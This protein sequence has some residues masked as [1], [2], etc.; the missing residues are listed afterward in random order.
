[1]RRALLDDDIL[2]HLREEERE[3]SR[4]LEAIRSVIAV[5]APA[6]I[7]NPPPRARPKPSTSVASVMIERAAAAARDTYAGDVRAIATRTIE[8]SPVLPVPTRTIVEAVQRAGIEIRGLVPLNAVS[9]LL[10]RSDDFVSNGR[11]GWTLK[12]FDERYG[13]S[14]KENEAP[15][16]DTTDASETRGWDAV[17]STSPA[18]INPF[19]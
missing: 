6:H 11:A 1:M 12:S 19:T 7:P 8:S 2:L 4:K 14:P 10:S 9:A 3:L 13:L 5:Y 17:A 18:N 15:S 16:G